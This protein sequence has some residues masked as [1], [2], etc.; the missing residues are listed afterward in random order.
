MEESRKTTKL[1]RTQTG[2]KL[3]AAGQYGCVF[4]P[5]LKE[6]RAIDKLPVNDKVSGETKLDKLMLPQEAELEFGISKKSRAS[7]RYGKS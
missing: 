3:L 6:T 5:T 2:G 7:K 1:I 4:V